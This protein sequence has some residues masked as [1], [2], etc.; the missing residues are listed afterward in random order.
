[1]VF[2]GF[3]K[4]DNFLRGHIAPAKWNNKKFHFSPLKLLNALLVAAAFKIRCK[5]KFYHFNCLAF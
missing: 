4:A 3:L 2:K 5:E 1:M